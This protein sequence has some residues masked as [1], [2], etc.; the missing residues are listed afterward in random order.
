M[1]TCPVLRSLQVKVTQPM[2]LLYG[3]TDL[4]ES[5]GPM[6]PLLGG[7][8]LNFSGPMLNGEEMGGEDGDV[9]C[10]ELLVK[11]YAAKLSFEVDHDGE[12]M[13]GEVY[14]VPRL[15]VEGDREDKAGREEEVVVVDGPLFRSWVGNIHI[16]DLYTHL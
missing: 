13:G 15:F 2:N 12:G 3:L 7:E 9:F 6:G 16:I 5:L 8:V 14:G 10:W 4:L 1:E 11:V